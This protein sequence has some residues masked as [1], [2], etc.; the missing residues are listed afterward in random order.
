MVGEFLNDKLK[1]IIPRSFEENQKKDPSERYKISIAFIQIYLET[2]QDLFELKNHVRIREDHD[3]GIFLE[4]CM[5][6]IIKNTKECAEA[7]KKGE[8]NHNIE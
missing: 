6:I 4:N 8:K 5:W 2:I 7:F 1:G 3:K